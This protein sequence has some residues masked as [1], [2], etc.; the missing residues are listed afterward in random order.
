MS[1]AKAISVFEANK[2]EV[3]TFPVVMGDKQS[4]LYVLKELL[5]DENNLADPDHLADRLQKLPA[6]LVFYGTLYDNSERAFR[7]AEEEFNSWY[8]LKAEEVN[9]AH[10]KAMGESSL[11]ASLKKP[12]TMDQLKGKVMTTYPEL[13]KEKKEVLRK[14][15]ER[16]SLMRRMVEGLNSAIKLV[17]SE[18]TLMTT[19]VNKGLV[20]PTSSSA[21]SRLN[22]FL[23]K[24]QA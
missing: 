22:G 11:P 20:E 7:E 3:L 18:T 1:I 16:L 8:S 15:E 6:I 2:E 17:Q 14:A 10:L 21:K 4:K 19:L 13:W 5:L 23:S 12:L 24:P 9:D